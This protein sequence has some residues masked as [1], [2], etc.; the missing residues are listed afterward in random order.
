[1][2]DSGAKGYGL[3]AGHQ[4]WPWWRK[5]SFSVGRQGMGIGCRLCAYH[6]ERRINI[7]GTHCPAW[8][9]FSSRRMTKAKI[10]HGQRY[11]LHST[12]HISH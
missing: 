5:Q 12:E 8:W 11:R 6:P 10:G 7:P 9:S 4:F 1:M 3:V 2:A